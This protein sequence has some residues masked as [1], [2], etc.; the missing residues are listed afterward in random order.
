MTLALRAS[1]KGTVM[2]RRIDRMVSHFAASAGSRQ[3]WGGVWNRS[4]CTLV[5]SPKRAVQASSAVKQ[6]TGASHVHK[7]RCN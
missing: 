4:R 7:Y 1:S 6:S 2:R 5:S 3:A